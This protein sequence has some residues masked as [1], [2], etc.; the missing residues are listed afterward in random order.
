MAKLTVVE[1]RKQI[2]ALEA[3]AARLVEEESK[4]SVAKVRALMN[5]LGVTL[6]HLSSAVSRK[7]SVVKT[8]IVGKKL[9]TAKRT[10]KGAAKYQDPKT[11]ATWSGVGRAPGWIAGA[12]NRDAF[13]VGKSGGNASGAVVKPLVAKKKSAAKKAS[14]RKIAKPAARRAVAV[15]KKAP[16]KAATPA[17]KKKPSA[18][19]TGPKAAAKKVAK[20]RAAT[21]VGAA[22]SAAREDG[23]PSAT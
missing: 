21:S 9:A 17:T 19:K 8:A 20:K 7:A 12:M 5:E 14:A 1:I 2:S 23:A 3:K 11:G 18:K 13:L 6:E 15:A 22:A 4:A 16:A 10:S